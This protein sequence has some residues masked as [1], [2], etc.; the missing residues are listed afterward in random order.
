MNPLEVALGI[1]T[2]EE[3]VKSFDWLKYIILNENP[4]LDLHY[5]AKAAYSALRDYAKI[6]DP[7]NAAL[8]WYKKLYIKSNVAIRGEA[9][10]AANNFFMP[11]LDGISRSPYENT[12]EDQYSNLIGHRPLDFKTFDPPQLVDQKA[13][14]LP[15]DIKPEDV[16]CVLLRN[17]TFRIRKAKTIRWHAAALDAKDGNRVDLDVKSY[18]KLIPLDLPK[19]AEKFKFDKSLYFWDQVNSENFRAIG[20][21]YSDKLKEDRNLIV[22]ILIS[23]VDPDKIGGAT[24]KN[25]LYVM[26][27]LL[28][29]V[30][31]DGNLLPTSRYPRSAIIGVRPH[32][33]DAFTVNSCSYARPIDEQGFFI[34]DK[35]SLEPY[36]EHSKDYPA[37]VQADDI[38]YYK[39]GHGLSEEIKSGVILPQSNKRVAGDLMWERRDSRVASGGHDDTI[40][41]WKAIKRCTLIKT[42]SRTSGKRMQ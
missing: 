32:F 22:D 30:L 6:T 16:V 31:F 25:T 18:Q 1:K 21:M 12:V 14:C 9:K 11:Y 36:T 19:H 8:G 15:E 20:A 26:T 38:I 39:T 42:D 5:A 4:N 10:A 23:E 3:A 7:K 27:R 34:R 29:Q 40:L 13:D 37:G 28:R 35:D 33:Q 41:R 24:E 2:E 17:N